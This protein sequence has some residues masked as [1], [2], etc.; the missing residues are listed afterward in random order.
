MKH[1]HF[2]ILPEETDYLLTGGAA[3]EMTGLIPSGHPDKD[4]RENYQDVL[5]YFPRFGGGIAPAI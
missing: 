1:P 4:E 5:P 2:P 3:T